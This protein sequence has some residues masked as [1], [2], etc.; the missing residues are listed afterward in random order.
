M[1]PLLEVKD[2]EVAFIIENQ[3]ITFVDKVSFSV[4]PGEILCIVGESGSGKS[5]TSLA[6]MGL[7]G[8]NGRITGGNILFKGQDLLLK[9]E[10]ELDQIRGSELTMIFQD[11]LTSLNPVFT[12]GTQIT[13]IMAAHLKI[14][15]KE[16]R[17]RAQELLYKVGLPDPAAVMKK[18]PHTLSGGMRQRVM[19][20]MA[21]ILNPRLLIADEPTT[22]LDVTIQAQIME[23]LKKLYK[24]LNMSVILITHDMGVVA[25]MADRVAVMYAG[26]IVEEAGAVS[27]FKEPEHPYTRALLKSIPSIRDDETR[28][29][30]PIK[31][32]VPEQ[33]HRI[34]GCRFANR[35]P[36]ADQNCRLEQKL[37]KTKDGHYKRC[38][39]N[40][41]LDNSLNTDGK[42][43]VK[44]E[45][46]TG[47]K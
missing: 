16:A 28:E 41:L 29:L 13:E 3:E 7:L 25:E 30:I 15:K 40:G 8:K 26:Q 42:E 47:G 36:Y 32:T 31:G 5:V 12:I 22:A 27:L 44:Q 35:C 39:R 20:A 38:W 43:Q 9:S 34:A 2:L 23:L 24:E 17:L 33:Y 19:I 6:I 14:S 11:A 10:K 1:K 18:Y 45:E 46:W 37:R 4:N 21:L